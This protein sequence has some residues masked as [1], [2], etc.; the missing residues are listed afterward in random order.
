[1]MYRLYA[2]IKWNCV[3]LSCNGPYTII[4]IYSL[5]NLVWRECGM[6][7][8]FG[9]CQS[10]TLPPCVDGGRYFDVLADTLCVHLIACRLWL[11]IIVVLSTLA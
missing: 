10:H 6:Y 8:T 2:I 9:G 1:M 3:Q 4:I 7:H 11:C 5:N